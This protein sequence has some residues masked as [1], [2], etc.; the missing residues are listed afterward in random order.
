M[1]TLHPSLLIG[2]YD[3]DPG[4]L[5]LAE[6]QERL[7]AVCARLGA[8]GLAGLIVHGDALDNGALAYL[9]GF[10]PKHGSAFAFVGAGGEVWI[11]APGGAAM[12]EAA[13]RLTWVDDVVAGNRLAERVEAWLA[14]MDAPRPRLGKVAGARAP[15]GAMHPIAARLAYRDRS[16]NVA[17]IQ[18]GE[19]EARRLGVADVRTLFS[20]DGGAVLQPFEGLDDTRTDPLVAYIAVRAAGY[21]AGGF[22]TLGE[23]P[24]RAREAADAALDA[25]IE[26]ARPGAARR[27]LAAAMR[28]AAIGLTPHPVVRD[29]LGSGLGLSLEEPPMLR[30]DGPTRSRPAGSTPCGPAS[31]MRPRATRSSPR[32]SPSEPGKPKFS[33]GRVRCERAARARPDRHLTGNDLPVGRAG[34]HRYL[35]RL[36]DSSIEIARNGE[37][38]DCQARLRM[39]HGGEG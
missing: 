36:E 5:P 37:K 2:N 24:S 19:R 4:R 16:G 20:L 13:K 34:F 29:E 38:N 32:S 39:R 3:W 23:P 21:W 12:I 18:A 31:P 7:A 10:T 1:R 6:F 35:K 33:G 17:A 26:A 11:L 22:V 15:A 27:D 9:T 28:P 25:M 14:G 30:P 8:R